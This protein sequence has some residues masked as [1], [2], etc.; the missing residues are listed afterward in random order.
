MVEHRDNFCGYIR[1]DGSRC[2]GEAGAS[3]LCKWHDH[4]VIKDRPGDRAELEALAR[5]GQ[6]MEG[7][8]LK[9]ADLRSL[10][11]VNMESD[12]GF[13][14]SHAN[15]DHADLRDAHLFHLNL[16]GSS[17][18]KAD[19]SGAS[20]NMADL[21]DSDLLGVKL[22]GA[23]IEHVHW[24]R[25]ILQEE[26]GR[27]AWR[28]GRC[29]EALDNFEQAEEI[30][31]NLRK[32]TESRGQFENAGGFFYREMVMRRHQ[33]PY[34]SLKRFFA[35]WVDLFCGYGEQPIR[36]ILC[37]LAFVSICAV[38]YFFLHINTGMNFIGYHPGAGFLRNLEDFGNCF[39]FSIVT[40]T[41]LGY[42]D[43]T[44]HGWA[45]PLA[46]FEAF[47]GSFTLALF[48]VVFVKKMTR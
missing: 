40:F 11:L 1:R 6:S 33:M 15:L 13:N 37:S 26:R 9:R 45:R 18:L 32:S 48:V 17:L 28:Q 24:G 4:D 42:G 16:R 25:R 20:L 21:C 10:N 22:T 41:T 30:Y 12:E 31:R 46:A 7:F 36:V 27:Q 38:L 35:K 29:D 44:P 3:G 23:R 8:S 34:W 2:E 39:Y 43:I 19:F 5:S 47:C 14:L